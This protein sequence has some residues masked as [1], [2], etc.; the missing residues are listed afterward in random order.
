MRSAVVLDAR[1]TEIGARRPTGEPVWVDLKT[2]YHDAEDV[3]A[4][5]ERALES[6]GC[7]RARAVDVVLHPP[8]VQQRTLV[9]I[10]SVQTRDLPLLVRN[11]HTRFFR[12]VAGEP[13]V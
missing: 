1:A 4:A 10:P 3:N 2:G 11:Q 7:A 8:L 5:I 12:A 9:G 6:V 13:V